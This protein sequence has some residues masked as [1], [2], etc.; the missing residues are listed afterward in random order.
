MTSTEVLP[1]A[2]YQKRATN[3]KFEW[4]DI[5]LSAIKELEE[6]RE[7]DE[8]LSRCSEGSDLLWSLRFRRKPGSDDEICSRFAQRRC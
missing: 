1:M 2:I 4:D 3:K 7:I 5:L 8:I 6:D